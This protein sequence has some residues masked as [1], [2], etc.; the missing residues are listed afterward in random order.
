LTVARN[1]NRLNTL[2]LRSLAEPGLHADG[3]GLYLSVS[4]TGSRS[5]TLI[6]RRNGKRTELGLGP[7][8]AVSLAQARER[9]QEAAS[10]RAQGVDPKRQWKSQRSED[11]DT[12]FGTVATDLITDR[13]AGWKNAKHIQQWEN[14]LKTYGKPIWD[15]PVGGISVDD[16]LAILRPIWTTKP[17]TA[18]RVRGRIEQVLDAAKVRGLRTGENPAAWRGNLALLLAKPRKGPKKHHAAMPYADVP[19]FMLKLR[20]AEGTAAR[21]LEL[22]IHTAVRTTEVLNATWEEFDLKGAIWT[23]PAERMKAGKVHRVPLA[24]PA[25]EVVKSL[26]RRGDYLFPGAKPGKPLSNMALAMTMRRLGLGQFTVHG[27]RS[28]FRDYAAEETEFPGEIAEQALAHQV[29]N[30]V[31]R[32][33]RR[34]DM[35]KRRRQLMTVWSSYL[36]N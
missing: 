7:F 8:P 24:A 30:E 13:K 10:L 15:K 28:S 17:E 32:A 3:N 34:T 11:Q 18:S 6:Y 19:G 12:S 25:M 1:I 21:A 4:K 33:Y 22:L 26:T 35:L 27:F 31:E 20:S 2:K 36:L 9:A 23:I 16:V 29:G 5:W 14:T